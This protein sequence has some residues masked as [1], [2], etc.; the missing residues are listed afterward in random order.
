MKDYFIGEVYLFRVKTHLSP[1]FC[2]SSKTLTIATMKK[3]IASL[4]ALT[5]IV[6]FMA[7]SPSPTTNTID[8]KEDSLA[9][10]RAKYSKEVMES[11][12]GKEK[13]AADSVFKNVKIFKGRPAEQLVRIMENGW[14]K[15]LGVSCGHCHN[16]KDWASE[17]KHDRAIAVDMVAMTGKINDDLLKNMPAY[18]SKT[19]KPTINCMTCHNGEAHPGRSRQQQQQRR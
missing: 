8:G 1:L 19:R 9:A 6:S 3:V 12:K 14:S 5:A 15:A 7:I 17:E 13:M 18:A 2:L 10:D 4:F 16:E 11:I